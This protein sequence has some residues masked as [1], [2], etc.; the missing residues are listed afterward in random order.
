MNCN[1]FEIENTINLTVEKE[2]YKNHL[3]NLNDE[4]KQIEEQLN[5]VECEEK[6]LKVKIYFLLNKN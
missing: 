1:K 3:D 4:I 5:I 6:Y 2:I